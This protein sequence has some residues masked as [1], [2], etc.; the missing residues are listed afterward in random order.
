MT[1][2]KKVFPVAAYILCVWQIQRLCSLNPSNAFAEMDRVHGGLEWNFQKR[3]HWGF[4]ARMDG[5][6]AD[7]CTPSNNHQLYAGNM[8]VYQRKLCYILDLR[9]LHLGNIYASRVD[10]NHLASKRWLQVSTINLQQV[11]SRIT[12]DAAHQATRLQAKIGCRKIRQWLDLDHRFYDQA[13]NKTSI[14]VLIKLY[15]QLRNEHAWVNLQG[16]LKCL[17]SANF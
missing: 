4:Q 8:E 10:E 16:L 7:I 12:H 14:F 3:Q 13:I 6:V 1:A 17:V 9:F 5:D 2:F 15:N 11:Y